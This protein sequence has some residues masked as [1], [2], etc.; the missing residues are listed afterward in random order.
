MAATATATGP[1]A[2]L[3]MA[4]PMAQAATNPAARAVVRAVKAVGMD[5]IA[6]VDAVAVAAAG[7]NAKVAHNA[8]A[9]TLRASPCR[10]TP[11]YRS[12]ANK[13]QAAQTPR[14]Q[15]NAPIALPANA[16]NEAAVVDVAVAVA[17]ATTLASATSSRVQKAVPMQQQKAIPTTT[18]ATRASNKPAKAVVTDAKVAMDG[19]AMD[20]VLAKTAK[21]ATMRLAKTPSRPSSVSP[22][23]TMQPLRQPQARNRRRMSL[24]MTKHRATR[25][26]N[27]ARNANATATA[28][29]ADPV[30]I[31]ANVKS[32]QTCASPHKPLHSL[33]R[34]AKHRSWR[35]KPVQHQ[36]LSLHQS[37]NRFALLRLPLQPRLPHQRKL[38]PRSVCPR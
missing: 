2:N 35:K 20:V 31:A 6:A 15:N 27:P 24:Q 26:V 25:T 21:V 16:V 36:S 5:A 4:D 33:T 3:A 19:A 7:V 32:A 29:N 34:Q 12:A 23:S 30:T 9:L 18:P 13:H 10:W 11:T 17:S 37:C 8:N 14:A 38:Y 1:V 28:V 22:R